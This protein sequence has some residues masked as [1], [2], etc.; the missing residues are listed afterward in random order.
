MGIGTFSNSKGSNAC[1]SPFENWTTMVVPT[2]TNW[3][4]ARMMANPI[5]LSKFVACGSHAQSKGSSG[6][7]PHLA[8]Q[9][10]QL[11]FPYAPEKRSA[12]LPYT[13]RRSRGA[14]DR[15][16]SAQTPVS[17]ERHARAA[18]VHLTVAAITT[19][20]KMKPVQS[21][22]DMGQRLYDS[23][24]AELPFGRGKPTRIPADDETRAWY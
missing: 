24:R 1:M 14:I 6:G 2:P 16:G 20:A 15:C 21:G 23:S 7:C 11:R 19:A 18:T 22:K 17:V 3:F 9:R 4:W 5:T 8:I 12:R 13:A 10:A